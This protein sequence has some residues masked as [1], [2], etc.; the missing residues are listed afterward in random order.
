MFRV[1]QARIFIL[2]IIKRFFDNQYHEHFLKDEQKDTCCTHGLKVSIGRNASNYVASKEMKEMCNNFEIK[3]QMYMAHRVSCTN[4]NTA[5]KNLEKSKIDKLK[6]G[7]GWYE[8]HFTYYRLER[9]DNDDD[10]DDD[11][12]V[13]KV[14]VKYAVYLDKNM[15]D[16]NKQDCPCVVQLMEIGKITTHQKFEHKGKKK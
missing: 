3:L 2:A 1:F 6:R 12:D 5:P 9:Y 14:P 8:R 11:V 15:A 10:D 13:E 4:Q 7:I 16:S